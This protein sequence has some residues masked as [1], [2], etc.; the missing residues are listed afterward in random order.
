MMA[1]SN[2]YASASAEVTAHNTTEIAANYGFILPTTGVQEIQLR[3]DASTMT[4]TLTAGIYYPW[5]IKLLHTS[6][7]S[8]TALIITAVRYK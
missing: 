7:A 4:V 3:D 2:Q 6:S 1:K 8:A 5:D